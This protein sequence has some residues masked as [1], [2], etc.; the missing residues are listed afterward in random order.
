MPKELDDCKTAIISSDLFVV[1]GYLQNS[2]FYNS[3]RKFCNKTKTWS[4]RTQ[5]NLNTNYFY[6]CS[7]KNNFYVVCETGTCHVNNLKSD[8]WNQKAAA[9]EVRHSAA[10]KVKFLLLGA[11]TTI[12]VN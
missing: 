4:C 10:S 5:L 7:F 2:E 6:I 12:M 3:I 1:G 8:E 9:K 11:L